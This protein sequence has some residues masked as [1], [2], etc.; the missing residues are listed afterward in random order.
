MY[1][2]IFTTE[3]NFYVKMN[4]ITKYFLRERIYFSSM[5]SIQF[6]HAQ[7]LMC[8]NFVL[9]T[10]TKQKYIFIIGKREKLG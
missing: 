1:T 5:I 3:L 4:L 6:E 8:A 9:T 7:K 2:Q 10:S